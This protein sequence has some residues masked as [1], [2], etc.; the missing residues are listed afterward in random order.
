MT[1][2]DTDSQDLLEPLQPAAT[3]DM[4][5]KPASYIVNRLLAVGVSLAR[6]RALAGDGPAGDQIA[7]AA[8]EVF[9][10]IH[11]IGA[12]PSGSATDEKAEL[13]ERVARSARQLESRALETV[14]LL[15]HRADLTRGPSRID[16]P[17]EIKRWRAF[18]D[19]AQQV[20]ERW[21][22]RA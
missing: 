18:A 3:R 14:T 1:I 21:E 22:Q 15:Q 9:Q 2:S 13:R 12:T 8:D 20:A 7:A 17:A 16:Y 11:D 5:S 19:Q 6:A 4:V 10:L